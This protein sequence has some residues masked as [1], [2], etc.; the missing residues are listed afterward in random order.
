ME[1]K[2]VFCYVIQVL[3]WAQVSYLKVADSSPYSIPKVDY[4][5]RHWYSWISASLNR[6]EA[7]PSF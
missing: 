1:N 5:D 4:L 2:I 7:N 3:K 6:R